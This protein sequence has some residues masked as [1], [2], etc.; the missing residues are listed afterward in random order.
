MWCINNLKRYDLPHLKWSLLN[1]LLLSNF[2]VFRNVTAINKKDTA[3]NK[4]NL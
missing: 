4:Y 3:N 2:Y 1:W